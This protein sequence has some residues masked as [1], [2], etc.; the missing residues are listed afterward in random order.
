MQPA[1]AKQTPPYNRIYFSGTEGVTTKL[2]SDIRLKIS[3]KKFPRSKSSN[4]RIANIIKTRRAIKKYRDDQNTSE[5]V[6]YKGMLANYRYDAIHIMIDEKTANSSQMIQLAI[7]D[8]DILFEKEII[9]EYRFHLLCQLAENPIFFAGAV[10]KAKT[11]TYVDYSRLD[12]LKDICNTIQT[13]I[14]DLKEAE[15][16]E[17]RLASGEKIYNDNGEQITSDRK[18]PEI[19]RLK[20][21]SRTEVGTGT[22]EPTDEE[23]EED[24][25]NMTIKK[26]W[27]KYNYYSKAERK[28]RYRTRREKAK[29]ENLCFY[30]LYYPV[31]PFEALPIEQNF[32]SHIFRLRKSNLL[33]LIRL[34]CQINNDQYKLEKDNTQK[35]KVKMYIPTKEITA[36]EKREL[37]QLGKA[38]GMKQKEVANSIP[39]SIKTVKRNWK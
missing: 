19:E 24:W 1:T 11:G 35:L 12:I 13:R 3:G 38:E 16:L 14:T 29:P 20:L 18:A 15:S 34:F 22:D 5:A 33:V 23:I 9:D 7:T 27:Q 2:E 36:T 32:E 30:M 28:E 17:E 25:S 31:K 39:C 8:E 21:L 10:Q 37:I 4:E 26:Y 6:N